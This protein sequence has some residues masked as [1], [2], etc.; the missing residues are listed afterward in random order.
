MEIKIYFRP[1][2]I[3]QRGGTAH[4]R[5]KR[6]AIVAAIGRQTSRFK[7]LKV[8]VAGGEMAFVSQSLP[9]KAHADRP[10]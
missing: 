5:R 10:S 4:H 6:P 3:T 2:R 8:R 9:S 7:T 1:A